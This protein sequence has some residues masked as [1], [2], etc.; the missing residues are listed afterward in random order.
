MP[1]VN[2]TLNRASKYLDPKYTEGPRSNETPFGEWADHPLQSWCMSFVSYI[3]D[4]VGQPIG[5]IAFCPTGV[6][7]F[8]NQAQLKAG[9]PKPGDV[10]FLYFPSLGRY[11]HTGFVRDVQGDW[12]IT[13]EGNSDTAGSRT[14]GSVVS[15]RRK[16]SGTRTVFGRPAYSTDKP[17]PTI[18]A[19]AK[20]DDVKF[21][22]SQLGIKADGDWGPLTQ[23][24]V[25]KFQQSHGLAVDG[26]IG[27]LTWKALVG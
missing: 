7:Y 5:K 3:L 26:V 24:A 27:P 9:P 20:G 22:Q 10:F 1:T 2:Y 25:I 4:Q 21:L 18:K 8:R 16:W 13:V 17:R 11:A 14:G 19:G 23:A 6:L 12:I 15:L